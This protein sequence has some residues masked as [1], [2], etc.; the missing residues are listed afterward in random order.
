MSKIS[1]MNEDAGSICHTGAIEAG[2][3]G[4]NIM[5][6]EM[7]ASGIIHTRGKSP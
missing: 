3:H 2:A 6:K 7:I 4:H 1:A 5:A